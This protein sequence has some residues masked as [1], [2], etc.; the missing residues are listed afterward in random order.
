MGDFIGT[1]GSPGPQIPKEIIDKVVIRATFP[2]TEHEAFLFSLSLVGIV[3][4][5][6]KEE[7]KIGNLRQVFVLCTRNGDF[8]YV[9]DDDG[10]GYYMPLIVLR[11]QEWRSGGW[12]DLHILATY[13]EEFC[14]HFWS[15]DDEEV[16]K[17]KVIEI[18]N[19]ILKREITFDNLYGPHWKLAYPKIYG[20]DIK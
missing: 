9:S 15:I 11:L 8:T 3:A 5:M 13:V 6:K 12:S 20:D 17:H 2:L 1:V 16:V 18:L 19:N 10:M 14:H 4:Q 7:F